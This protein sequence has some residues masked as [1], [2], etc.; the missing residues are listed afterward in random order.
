MEEDEAIPY[1]Q[2]GGKSNP[3]CQNAMC[4]DVCKTHVGD[5]SFGVIRESS[6]ASQVYLKLQ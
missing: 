2:Y 5:N 1:E 3:V 4:S 6:E